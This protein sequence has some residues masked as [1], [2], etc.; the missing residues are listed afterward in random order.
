M[1][2]LADDPTSILGDIYKKRRN[3]RPTGIKK[4]K[5]IK[6]RDGSNVALLGLHEYLCKKI[7]STPRLTLVKRIPIKKGSCKIYALMRIFPTRKKLFP[8]RNEC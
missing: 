1:M 3:E 7:S 5:G 6:E 4:P 8:P 2:P